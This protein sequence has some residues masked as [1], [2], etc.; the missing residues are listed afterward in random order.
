MK[1]DV[2][3]DRSDTKIV[4]DIRGDVRNDINESIMVHFSL[5]EIME[6]RLHPMIN[7]TGSVCNLLSR[8]MSH[9]IVK[10]IVEELMKGSK[11]PTSCPIKKVSISFLKTMV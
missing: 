11:V 6:S 4:I 2:K 8:F 3:V 1:L 7:G 10:F 9:P 5:I